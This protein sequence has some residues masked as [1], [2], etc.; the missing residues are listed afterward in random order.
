MADEFQV[1]E[2]QEQLN[3]VIGERLSKKE[4]QVRKEYEGYL[5]PAQVDEKLKEQKASYES[6]TLKHKEEVEQ[7]NGTINELQ[8]KVK[9]YETDSVKTR[10]ALEYGI[11]YEM[12]SRLHGENEEDIKKDASIM[13]KYMQGGA[14]APKK[15]SESQG[16]KN[17][18]L[19][20]MLKSL[21]E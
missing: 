18:P 14:R 5:S 8:A 4:A 17:G 10:I 1:I 20:N 15:S 12:A 9:Q 19:K 13:A 3:N 7:L 2:S 16:G 11:P 6:S 21:K